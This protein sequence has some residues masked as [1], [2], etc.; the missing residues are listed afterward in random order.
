MTALNKKQITICGPYPEPTGGVSVHVRRLIAVMRLYFNV[1]LV[2]ESP[3]RKD[4]IFNLRSFAFFTYFRI[5]RESDLVHVNSSVAIFRFIHVFTA[6]LLNK[7]IIIT[8]HSFRK[9]GLASWFFN[10]FSFSFS[11]VNIVVGKEIFDV[12]P[13][14][15]V[16]IPAFIKPGEEE[17]KLTEPFLSV[18]N[19]LKSSGRKLIVSNASRLDFLEGEEIYGFSCLID[20]FNDSRLLDGFSLVLNVSSIQG[21]ESYYLKLKEI[22]SSKRLES[23]VFLFN[24]KMDFVGLLAAADVYV[25]A[26]IT[27]GDALSVR[28]ALMLGVKTIASD[29]VLRPKGTILYET[30]N[31]ESLKHAICFGLPSGD[32]LLKSFDEEI[33]D[34][35]ESLLR[36]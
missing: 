16:L 33:L 8:I 35:Y 10:Y 26:T 19:D 4:G 15:K 17:F 18:V 32:L 27:D 29:C 14:K 22:I 24:E 11:D 6:W 1:S 36:H 9:V 28:E 34:L 12:F 3:I 5:I 30:K 7:K 2:D 13:F 21:R 20:M 31:V 25:R 23:S